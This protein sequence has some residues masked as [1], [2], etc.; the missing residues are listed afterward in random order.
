MSPY[1]RGFNL[2][3]KEEFEFRGLWTEM[4]KGCHF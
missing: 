3:S 1:T 2:G 4:G